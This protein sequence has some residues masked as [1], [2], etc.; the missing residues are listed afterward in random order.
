MH[1]VVKNVNFIKSHLSLHSS[2]NYSNLSKNKTASIYFGYYMFILCSVRLD[3]SCTLK[4][5][6]YLN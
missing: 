2:S 6:P 3:T 5:Q 4:N 1:C